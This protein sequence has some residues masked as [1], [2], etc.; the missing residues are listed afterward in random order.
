MNLNSPELSL[1]TRHLA[2]A[3]SPSGEYAGNHVVIL[4]AL[5]DFW[6]EAVRKKDD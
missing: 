4:L 5:Y 3:V 1:N 2:D 6:E